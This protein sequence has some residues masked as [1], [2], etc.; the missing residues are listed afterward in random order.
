M[1]RTDS[2]PIV[3]QNSADMQAPAGRPHALT[4]FLGTY[5]ATAVMVATYGVLKGGLTFAS[6][7][8]VGLA[9]PLILPIAAKLIGS[10]MNNVFKNLMPTI[11]ENTSKPV[12][13]LLS[14]KRWYNMTVL[15]VLPV[16]TLAALTVVTGG[17]TAGVAFS[18]A[19]LW[20]MWA[21]FT[22]VSTLA[23]SA[24]DWMGIQAGKV[25]GRAA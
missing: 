7:T 11:K 9:N 15:S 25:L 2:P 8:A 17:A 6:A 16:L 18:F 14:P 22:V 5:L 1:A 3:R 21:K 24:G 4:A 20:P 12:M 10:G 23:R 13:A 19:A